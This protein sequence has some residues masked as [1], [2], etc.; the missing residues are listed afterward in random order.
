MNIFI[1]YASSD[2]TSFRISDIAI[3]MENTV[4]IERVFYWDRDSTAQKSIVKYMEESITVSDVILI[5][6]TEA[7]NES[8]P[9]QQETDMAVYLNKR[10]VP[11]FQDIND[12]RLSLRPK[13]GV[14]YY[15]D[16]FDSFFKELFMVVT[17]LLPEIPQ[18][19]E[20]AE[21]H[22][23]PLAID[24]YRAMKSL[25]EQLGIIIPP[26]EPFYKKK[27]VRFFTD[28]DYYLNE[29]NLKRGFGFAAERNHL[30]QLKFNR[31]P[32][33][34]EENPPIIKFF[35][36]A[37]SQ[38]LYLRALDLSYQS[39]SIIPNFIGKLTQLEYFNI[40]NNKIQRFPKILTQLKNL[41]FFLF[42]NVSIVEYL[43]DEIFITR[44]NYEILN[45]LL[46]NLCK[47]DLYINNIPYYWSK[48]KAKNHYAHC[49][50]CGHKLNF[51]LNDLPTNND[52]LMIC[53]KCQNGEFYNFSIK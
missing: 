18:E 43:K 24:E 9:V 40:R 19:E 50:H 12:V 34:D 37:L 15:T 7:S 21:F 38:L 35:P 16:D 25:E 14:K 13:R 30:I 33:E 52:N 46:E 27:N 28:I 26:I 8:G 49:V 20:I 51:E 23:I 1:S 48:L 32:D 6:C 29:D 41:K 22:G 10:I 45:S 4:E 53:P 11:I 2:L 31:V 5:V 47:L 39:I 17:E 36:D 42:S 44:S 3:R